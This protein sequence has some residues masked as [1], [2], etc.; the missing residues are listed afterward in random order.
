MLVSKRTMVE[1]NDRTGYYEVYDMVTGDLIAV[2]GRGGPNLAGTRQLTLPDGKVVTV[3]ADVDTTILENNLSSKPRTYSERTVAH[4]CQ[5]VATGESVTR[6]CNRLDMPSYATLCRWR[7]VHP[8]ID[9]DLEQARRDRAEYLRDMAMQEALV[10]DESNIQ[11]QKLKHEAYKWAAAKDLPSRYEGKS[12][13][14]VAVT[15]TTIMVATGIDRGERSV[16]ELHGENYIETQTAEPS[17]SSDADD[18]STT[19]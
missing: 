1:F 14:D 13:V 6:A 19:G 18:S 5:L 10:A 11:S 17:G 7:R 16:E 15:A 4:L 3:D 12:K 2:Q 9:E 8:H